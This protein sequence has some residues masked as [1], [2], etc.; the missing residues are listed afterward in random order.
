MYINKLTNN[1]NNNIKINDIINNELKIEEKLK[2]RNI[3]NIQDIYPDFNWEDYKNLNPYLYIIGLRTKE[4]YENNYLVEGRYVGRIYNELYLK[5]NISYHILLATIGKKTIFRI[6]ELLKKQLTNIDFL[7]IVFDGK[8]NANNSNYVIKFCE[9]FKCKVNIIIEENNL[10]YWGHGIRNKYNNLNGDFI[11]HIDDDDIIYDNTFDTIR[12]Y[13][14]DINL[15]Y[16]FKIMLENN[17]IIWK[18]KNI[19][20]TKISTQNGIIPMQF[21]KEGFWGLRYGGDFDFYKDLSIKFNMVFINKLIYR[22]LGN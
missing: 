1:I 7:T 12:K 15:I 5:K 4:D 2:N 17:D 21:N 3:K 6:L 22:K 20:H 19:I 9:D 11:Y 16:I 13:C 18:E 14:K 10:G 8:E